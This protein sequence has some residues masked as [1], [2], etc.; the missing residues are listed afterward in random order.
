MQA[1]SIRRQLI[2]AVLVLLAFGTSALVLLANP[3]RVEPRERVVE[4][5]RVRVVEAI[6]RSVVLRVHS[7]GTVVPPVQRELVPE[8]SGRVV[9]VSPALADGGAFELG[10]PLLRIDAADYEAALRHAKADVIRTEAEHTHSGSELQ[11]RERLAG[12]DVVSEEQLSDARRAERVTF[13]NLE[14]ARVSL[15][16][17]QRNL[18]RTEL[19]APFT[20][21]VREKRVDV[22][23]FV[24]RGHPVGTLYAIDQAEVRLPLSD[25]ELMFLEWPSTSGV[26]APGTQ[27]EVTLRAKLGGVERSW[28]GRIVR[29]DGAIDPRT[30]MVHVIARVDDPYG[31]RGADTIA[32]LVVGLF[33][34]AEIRGRVEPAAIVL[35]RSSLRSRNS[36]L[37]VDA[38]GRLREREVGVVRLQGDEAVVTSGLQ[39]GELV[40]LSDMPMFVEGMPV[41]VA[42]APGT[43]LTP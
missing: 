24:E 22:G 15:E 41:V 14:D 39:P 12:S 23:Q 27:P 42:E 28:R 31:Q 26:F 7:Q 16:E 9:W 3:L 20:G 29:T 5:P 2:P 35:P 10:D 6:P 19:G 18:D 40:C 8:V 25:A 4:R 21:R 33:V 11:R 43:G 17:A 30:R 36:V 34:K 13:A 38:E 37:L 32:P 1:D